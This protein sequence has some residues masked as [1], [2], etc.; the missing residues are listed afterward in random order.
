MEQ[1]RT[2]QAIRERTSRLTGGRLSCAVVFDRDFSPEAVE[3][4]HR[5]PSE[6]EPVPSR[7]SFDG[8]VVRYDC[9]EEEEALWRLALEIFLVKT[10]RDLPPSEP[11]RSARRTDGEIRT[12]MG[13]RKLHLG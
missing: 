8:R 1:Q 2:P 13:L 6:G 3:R 9:A 4:F 7:F 12:R 11:G 5:L 10:F